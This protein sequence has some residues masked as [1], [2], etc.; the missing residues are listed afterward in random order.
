MVLI[1]NRNRLH[2]LLISILALSILFS[3]SLIVAKK[4]SDAKNAATDQEKYLI[5][6]EI[7]E[8]LLYLFKEGECIKKYPIASGKKGWPSPIGDWTIIN[9]GDWGEG[10]GGRWLGL[11]VRWG[12]YGIHGTTKENTIGR[13]ASHGCIRMY[14]RHIKELYDI[15]QVGTPVI[16]RNGIFGPFGTGFRDLVPG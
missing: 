13:S 8:K 10:F 4:Y 9:K 12:K 3:G 5:L 1:V 15:V 16:I 14:N 6:I 7:D 11:D 2:L